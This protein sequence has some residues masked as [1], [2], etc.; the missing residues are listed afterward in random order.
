MGG[1]PVSSRFTG[2]DELEAESLELGEEGAE[3]LG[4]VEEHLI[5][6]VLPF[7]EQPGSRLAGH[8]AGPRSIRAMETGRIVPARARRFAAASESHDDR[9]WQARAERGQL[10]SDPFESSGLGRGGLH[11][12]Q[13]PRHPLQ[14]GDHVPQY[15]T[16]ASATTP[17]TDEV[18]TAI[19]VWAP[20]SAS[21]EVTAF[22]RA[23]V[24]AVDPQN[25]QRARSLL[26]AAGRLGTFAASCGVELSFA[27]CFHPSMIERLVA[28]GCEGLAPGTRRTLRTNLRFLAARVVPGGRPAPTPLSRE[29]AKAPYVEAELCGYLSLA[30]AQPTAA[31]RHRL[32]ALI[33]LGAGAG[34]RGAELRSIRGVHVV[35][36]SGGVVVE[37]SGRRP[38]PVPVLARYHYRL[39]ASA[40]VAGDGF[41]IGGVS[42]VRRNVSSHLVA[43]VSG[44]LDLPRLDVGRLRATWLA[45]VAA[46]LGLRAFLDAAGV[47][48]SQRLGDLVA[49][50]PIL[51]ETRTVTLLGGVL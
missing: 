6:L 37:V 33:C 49:G 47:T 8:L 22:A 50:L 15:R 11:R 44:G 34:L 13:L 10:P 17:P 9:A 39:S 35:S 16:V 5:L 38:R 27:V 30:D 48:C 18:H 42:E 36:R 45:H 2:L 40:A 21:E 31:L 28:V 20:H 46:A 23:A 32:S 19:A 24:A 7:A 12:P 29:R 41:L 25:P 3:L 26:F 14:S 4:V 51:D 43:A 1:V